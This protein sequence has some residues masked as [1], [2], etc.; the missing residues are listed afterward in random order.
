[1]ICFSSTPWVLSKH[2]IAE[3]EALC[4][5]SAR[6]RLAMHKAF[7]QLFSLDLQLK[8]SPPEQ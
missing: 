1:M 5:T 4:S 3:M 6:K 2:L 8:T 7:L